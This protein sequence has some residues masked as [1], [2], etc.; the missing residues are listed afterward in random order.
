MCRF[1]STFQM[2]RGT[3]VLFAGILTILL[4]NRRLHSHHWFGMVRTG[5]HYPPHPPLP[6]LLPR[7]SHSQSFK[8]PAVR[9][10]VGADANFTHHILEPSP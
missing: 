3:L 2:L 1:A 10:V 9:P 8:L 5:L 4:L 7:V 6:A